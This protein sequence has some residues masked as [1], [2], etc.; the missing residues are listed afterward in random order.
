[1]RRP[2]FALL[3]AGALSISACGPGPAPVKPKAEPPPESLK[4]A[5][6]APHAEVK[7]QEKDPAGCTWVQSEG[8]V[9][10]GES[11]GIHQARAAAIGEAEMSAMQDFL[12]VE[13]KSRFLDFQQE[14]LRDQQSL[15]EKLLQT[16]RNGRILKEPQI[17]V[18]G[19]RD[20]GSCEGC[21]YYVKAR[22]CIQPIAGDSDKDFAVELSISRQRF[23]EGDEAKITVHSTRDAYVYLYDV[24]MDGVTS[25]LVPNEAA[26]QVT[27]VAGKSWEYPDAAAKERG[28]HLIA[29]LPDKKPPVSAETIR[30]IATKV[31]LSGRIT[32]PSSGGFMGVYRRMQAAKTDWAEDAQAFT[33]YKK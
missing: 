5:P 13:V 3:A 8:T 17:L 15:V 20:V 7:V 31:P 26:A 14:G 30:V 16:T 28:V 6:D 22:F 18:K 33:I 1:M 32:D 12:G 4:A 23:E 21:Q 19:R 9:T 2:F 24:D 11:D 10:V 29:Q 27:V 25:L